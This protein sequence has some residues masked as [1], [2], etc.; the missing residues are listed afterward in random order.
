MK[1]KVQE[2]AHIDGHQK[3]S[4]NVRLD[5]AQIIANFYSRYSGLVNLRFMTMHGGP[6]KAKPP[7]GRNPL[8]Q[9]S[10]NCGRN[11]LSRV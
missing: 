11:G 8:I 4:D 10:A 2:Y 5:E 9:R 7:R 6:T 1:H 3:M